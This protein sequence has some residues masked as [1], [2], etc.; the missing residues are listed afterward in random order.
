MPELPTGIGMG[1][2]FKQMAQLGLMAQMGAA[3]KGASKETPEMSQNLAQEFLPGQSSNDTQLTPQTGVDT[4]SDVQ[5]E[6]PGA[7]GFG[8]TKGSA[9]G[10]MTQIAQTE[11]S[12]AHPMN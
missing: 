11:A 4:S 8:F 1:K 2:G 3:H 7:E 5:N 6:I 10:K 9:Y 12:S